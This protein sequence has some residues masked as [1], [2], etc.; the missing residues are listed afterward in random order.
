MIMHRIASDRLQDQA[1]RIFEEYLRVARCRITQS[2]RLVLEHVFSRTDHF[3]ADEVAAALSLGRGRVSRATVYVTLDLLARAGLVRKIRDDTDTHTHYE[4]VLGQPE[5]EHLI[6]DRCGTFLEFP[7]GKI[8]ELLAEECRRHGFRQRTHRVVA[9]GICARC[10]AAQENRPGASPQI[11][12]PAAEERSSHGRIHDT[13]SAM[14]G[15]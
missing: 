3:T 13:T 12:A 15:V 7:G 5:H 6:C 9:F 14:A 4:P 8:A 11:P 2:R 1:W 10:V